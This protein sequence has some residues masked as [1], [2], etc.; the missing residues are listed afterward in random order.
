M[1][2]LSY[3]NLPIRFKLL[4]IYA[5]L[6]LVAVAISIG[7]IWGVSVRAVHRDI[8]GELRNTTESIRSM[9]SS[10]SDAVIRNNLRAVAE[11]NRQIVERLHAR[12]A[13]GEMTT[14]EAKARAGAILLSQVIGKT[15]YVYAID[16]RGVVRVHPK[17]ELLGVDLS[18]HEFVREQIRRREGYQE[19]QWKNPEDDAPRAKAVYMT[20][21]APWDWIIAASSYREEFIEMVQVSEFADKVRKIRIGQ[22]GYAYVMDSKGILVIHPQ[23]EGESIY[24]ERDAEGRYFIRDIV[25]EKEGY[26]DYMWKNPGEGDYRRK[27]AVYL[28][29]PA[30]DWIVVS[31]AYYSEFYQTIHAIMW[32]IVITGLVTLLVM[33]PLTLLVNKRLVRGLGAAS[34]AARHLAE[35][36]LS[37]DVI[38]R[39]DDEIGQLLSAVAVMLESLRGVITRAIALSSE[40]NASVGEIS[41]ALS[42][43]AATL[44]EQAASVSQISSTMEEFSATSTQIAENANAVVGIAD[45][46]VRQSRDGVAAVEQVMDRMVRIN[47][48]NEQGIA[49]ILALRKKTEEITK[50]M[51]IINT[52]ADQTK[53]IA[54]NAAIEASGAGEAGRRF[55]VV[56][57]EIRRLADSVMASTGEIEA[58]ISDIQEATEHIVVASEKNTKEIGGAVDSFSRTVDLLN[59]ILAAAQSTVDAAK[60]ISLSTQ[61]QKTAS[62]QVVTALREIDEG[63]S[64]T[65]KSINQLSDISI[66]LA[67]LSD[68]M[69]ELMGRFKL[70]K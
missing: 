7:V 60:Q 45:N 28:Y 46:T 10:T 5:T 38:S 61:Q 30:F 51:E 15:G 31:T 6:M 1:T 66:K 14:E 47:Q 22:T 65:S 27:M 68:D 62:R 33:V 25:S 56:A 32:V 41:V 40:V 4:I 18:E 11:T 13:A 9:I 55:S 20:H 8:L 24:N 67:T 17:P 29:I 59:G 37:V 16:S 34:N 70:P 35:C 54:F 19:Y 3:R 21:F 44:S 42:E 39:S 43:Q 63:T 49:Q 69:T 52:I 58:K 12:V 48:D 2:K 53:L 36:D 50:V 26:T 57:V 23:L 64:Q